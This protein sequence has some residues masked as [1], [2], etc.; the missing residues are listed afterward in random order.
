MPKGKPNQPAPAKTPPIADQL[1]L[2]A[3]VRGMGP[4]VVVSQQQQL[5]EH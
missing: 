5:I 2:E 1:A 3:A 4:T